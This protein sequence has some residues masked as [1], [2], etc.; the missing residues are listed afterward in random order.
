MLCWGHSPREWRMSS[1][2]VRMSW[3]YTVAV[4]ADGSYSPVSTDLCTVH[5]EMIAW[6]HIPLLSSKEPSTTLLFLN[7]TV[8]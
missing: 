2:L 7:T 6:T 8:S 1:M 4:P 3:P 5:R